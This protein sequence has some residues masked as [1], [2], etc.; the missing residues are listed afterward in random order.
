MLNA[1][2]GIAV[3]L[4]Q[5]LSEQD[6][7]QRL[8]GAVRRVMP[9][10]A[11]ALLKYENGIL[12]PVAIDG[13]DANTLG[14]RFDPEEQPRLA[15]ILSS[16]QPIRFPADCTLPDPYDGLVLHHEGALAVHSCMGCALY[17]ENHLL[18]ILTLDGMMPHMF[19]RVGDAIMSTFSAL[20]AAAMQTAILI[21]S[22]ENQANQKDLVAQELV[23]EALKKDGGELIGDSDV[24]ATLREEIALVAGSNLSV[25][26][27]GETGVGKEL[28]ARTIHARS[29][30][31]TQPL[32]H[33]NCAALPESIA[34]SEL[35][36]HTKGSFTGANS[37]RGGKFELA[38]GGTLFLDEVG[39]LSLNIQAKMLRALQSG[40]IQRVGSD[41][42]IH[43]D[44]RIMAATNRDLKEEVKAGRFRR[45]LY[46]R[47]GVFPLHVPPLR[48]RFGDLPKLTGF[49][50]EKLRVKFGINNLN[51]TKAA[52]SRLS[53]YDWPGNV[54]ELE[55]VISRAVLRARADNHS[56][57]VT[58]DVE[59]CDLVEPEKRAKLV[60]T[61][62]DADPPDEQLGIGEALD[63]F[64]RNFIRRRL[65]SNDGNWSKTAKSLGVNSSNL[66][67]LAK[68]L[69]LK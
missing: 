51:I 63:D 62:P 25:L 29:E 33:I 68:R 24:M 6:R 37:D 64:Q 48:L 60:N 30:R 10:D 20:A 52:L 15:Q 11:S 23:V 13:L 21:E 8:L 3:D 69:G 27:T 65:A 42:M 57:L 50:L 9:C 67:R 31:A 1:L 36:G 58:I 56:G 26:I 47:L 2:L 12:V 22:L 41:K 5:N 54:R 46:H 61:L 28:V 39:E 4:T 7:Y 59:H 34:E 32:V 35:F 45:D 40:E 43:V 14:R 66:H 44:V 19:D 16:K 53:Q 55:H 17:I 18:G 38:H 49:F